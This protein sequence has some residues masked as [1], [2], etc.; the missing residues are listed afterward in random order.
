[1]L[2]LVSE[3]VNE[4]ADLMSELTAN[5]MAYEKYV[6]ISEITRRLSNTSPEAIVI[7]SDHSEVMCSEFCS[8]IKS[9]YAHR[10]IRIIVISGDTSEKMEELIFDAGADEFVLKP[11]RVRALVK[12]I[13]ARINTV[14]PSQQLTYRNQGKPSI[15][16]DKESFS[17]YVNQLFIPLSRKEFELL[18]LIA[19]Q[20]GK[21]FTREEIFK[22]IWKKDR[23]TKERTIDVHILRLRKKLGNDLITTQKG[24]GYRF[25]V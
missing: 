1:M 2:W 12:R 3:R 9:S 18:F 14:I 24:I 7:D 16:I 15:H 6:K 13:K 11:Y 25:I 19:S 10:K 4:Y 8:R 5:S 21:V 23:L 22:K 20:P 17:V